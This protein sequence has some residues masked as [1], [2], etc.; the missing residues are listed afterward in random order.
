RLWAKKDDSGEI[1]ILRYT[2]ID[3]LLK[4]RAYFFPW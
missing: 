1:I 2:D 4:K 3:P